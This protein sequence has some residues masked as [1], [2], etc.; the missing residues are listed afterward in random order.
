MAI[1]L[2]RKEGAVG[3]MSIVE[4][5]A[6]L[7]S[8]AASEDDIVRI[9]GVRQPMR[10]ADLPGF[11]VEALGFERVEVP[12]LSRGSPDDV[13]GWLDVEYA[14]LLRRAAAGLLI[15]LPLALA[16]SAS[17]WALGGLLDSEWARVAAWS[18]FPVVWIGYSTVMESREAAATLGKRVLGLRALDSD[19]A[20][21]RLGVA[22]RRAVLRVASLGIFGLGYAFCLFSPRR[23]A[24]HDRATGAIVIRDEG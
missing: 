12:S 24:F 1:Y 23:Q 17:L 10:I 11:G 19:G 5:R 15:D 3:P 13:Y 2:I 4:L 14:S 9:D 18:I 20:P 21:L 8:G 7:A 22:F 16:P 6:R